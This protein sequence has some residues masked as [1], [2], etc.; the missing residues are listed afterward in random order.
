MVV[1]MA[2]SA[3]LMMIHFLLGILHAAPPL[4]LCTHTHPRPMA[5]GKIREK[6]MRMKM[7]KSNRSHPN[8]KVIVAPLT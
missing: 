1:V 5:Q 6:K 2:A 3:V 4:L 7:D 8:P